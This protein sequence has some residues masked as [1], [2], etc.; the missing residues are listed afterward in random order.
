MKKTG[1]LFLASLGSILFLTFVLTGCFSTP[2]PFEQEYSAMQGEADPLL[3]GTE[4]KSVNDFS[5]LVDNVDY[6]AFETGGLL[7]YTY[8]VSNQIGYNTSF[9]NRWE[10]KGNVV[11]MISN[12]GYTQEIGRIIEEDGNTVIVGKGENAANKTWNFKMTKQ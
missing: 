11:T 4:W 5:P 1:N 10:R 3:S 9:N 6:Y 12:E 7:K 2:H 8:W